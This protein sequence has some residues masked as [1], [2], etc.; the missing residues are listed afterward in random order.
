MAICHWHFE[1]IC[2]D[3]SKLPQ[4]GGRKIILSFLN[5]VKFGQLGVKSSI[6][7]QDFLK[8]SLNFHKITKFLQKKKKKLKI[9]LKKLP[10]KSL[11]TAMAENSNFNDANYL[12]ISQNSF[13]NSIKIPKIK[14]QKTQKKTSSNKKKSKIFHSRN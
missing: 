2:D 4:S 6:Y 7:Q 8:F 11:E 13:K 1:G 5:V 9:F 14:N 10:E 12:K 3:V